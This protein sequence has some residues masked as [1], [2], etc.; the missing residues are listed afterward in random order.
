MNQTNYP[1]GRIQGQHDAYANVNDSI[2]YSTTN[3]KAYNNF[4]NDLYNKQ[5][6][7][8]YDRRAFDKNE[9]I[10]ELKSIE[11]GDRKLGAYLEEGWNVLDSW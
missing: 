10:V 1:S 4:S 9:Y 8:D 11:A 6:P 7:R 2:M 5:D 3:N